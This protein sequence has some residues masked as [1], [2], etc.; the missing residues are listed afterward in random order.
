[1]C[2]QKRTS[3]WGADLEE[4]NGTL[5]GVRLVTEDGD[6]AIGVLAVDDLGRRMGGDPKSFQAHGNTPIGSD[7][8]LVAHTPDVGPPGATGYRAQG[9]IML[10]LRLACGCIGGASEFAVDFLGVAV[11]T[12]G[13]QQGVGRFR[14]GDALGREE[15]RQ[16]PLPV[17]VLPLDFSLGL[18]C[19]GVAQGYA[20]EVE[21]RPEL[22]KGIWALRKEHAVAIDIEFERKAVF[23][24]SGGEE[25]Q[26]S[27]QIFPVVDGGTCADTG[28]IIQEV[29]QWIISLVPRKPTMWGGIQLPERP[30]LEALPAA[31]G[32][33]WARLGQWMS[34]MMAQR[35]APNRSGVQGQAQAA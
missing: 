31:S 3:L 34:Q 7:G 32:S 16:P 1:V 5:V 4:N 12:Q 15:S 33:G 2:E 21:R 8:D 6:A 35:P 28:A 11:A 26:V 20:V 29:K 30:D 22:G 27:E 14:V 24:K 17:L 23:G 9:I 18:R 13:G 25:V 19:S 10:S